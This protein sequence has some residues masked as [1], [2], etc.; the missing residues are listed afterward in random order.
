P[1][2]VTRAVRPACSVGG[3]AAARRPMARQ[4]S[5]LPARGRGCRQHPLLYGTP[6]SRRSFT[7]LEVEALTP[8]LE[9]TFSQ[10]L[11]LRVG[12]RGFAKKLEAAGVDAESEAE[13]ADNEPAE[14]T[15]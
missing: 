13:P 7:V 15:Q 1:A 14:V 11:Q 6:M 8:D 4:H 5:R 3:A 10:L 9:S 12:L 2:P